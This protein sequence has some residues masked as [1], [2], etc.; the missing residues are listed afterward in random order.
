MRIFGTYNKTIY[1]NRKTG[2]TIFL[3]NLSKYD[4][5][6]RKIYKCKGIIPKYPS[7]VSLSL[8]GEIE[9][10]SNGETV[11]IVSTSEYDMNEARLETSF[12]KAHLPVGLGQKAA[13]SIEKLLLEQGKSLY[14]FINTDGA[15][16]TISKIRGI[17]PAKAT[18]FINKVNSSLLENELYRSLSKYGMSY[19]Q[20]EM[21]IERFGSKSKE[22]LANDVYS[23]LG[24]IGVPFSQID[25]YAKEIGYK[26]YD[27]RR[28]KKL[29]DLAAEMLISY[30]HSYVNKEEFLQ[31]FRLTESIVSGFDE[32]IPDALIYLNALF[33][34]SLVYENERF[35]NANAMRAESIIA[36]RLNSFISNK[37]PLMD[38]RDIAKYKGKS[39]LDDIQKR[40]FDFLSETD[41]C[42][43]IG[44]PGTGKTSSIKDFLNAY[45]SEYPSKSYALCAPTGR[46]AQRLKESTNETAVTINRLLEFTFENDVASPKRNGRNLLEQD[47]IIVDEF[48][49]V[50][51]FLFSQLLQAMKPGCKLLLVGDW[52][53]LQSVEPGDLLHDLVLSNR[54]RTVKL[55]ISHRQNE[56]SS[57]YINSNS[58]LRGNGNIIE[59]DSFELISCKNNDDGFALAS[60]LF[61][62]EYSADNISECL[63]M[64]PTRRGEY[65]T[66]SFNRYIQNEIHETSEPYISFGNKTFYV[67]ERIMSTRNTYSDHEFY[68]GDLWRVDTITSDTEMELV[69]VEDRMEKITDEY[70]DILELAYSMTIHKCQGTEADRCIVLLPDSMS[71]HL[72]IKS[73]LYTAITRA[74]KKIT[75]ISVNGMFERYMK[76][77]MNLVRHSSVSERLAA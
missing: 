37:Q 59:D 2:Y 26:F 48:S 77:P 8:T 20:V 69:G 16:E 64:I 17:T 30:G 3:F 55:E 35:Y 11:F 23:S 58:L 34:S 74:K 60:K 9:A 31:L 15:V 54:F 67:D 50:G 7:E 65:G 38:K 1:R 12:I 14:D 33:S 25:T 56:E 41:V 53:Q 70:F 68:N 73:L 76:A 49:M 63:A 6:G 52:N 21:L 51:I 36:S 61:L 13:E 40:I 24:L 66:T 32:E 62:K 71:K 18:A 27:E 46:A 57:I 5:N 47:L 44:G 45:K 4:T 22:I 10:D 43:L 42:L 29:C 75:I 72:I 28:I 39:R 19:I